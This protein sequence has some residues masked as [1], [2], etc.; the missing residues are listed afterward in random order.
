M[1]EYKFDVGK[2]SSVNGF[3]R[4]IGILHNEGFRGGQ[5]A[6]NKFEDNCF[7]LKTDSDLIYGVVNAW[8]KWLD[9]PESM[10]SDKEL[11]SLYKFSP[12]EW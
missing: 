4:L 8:N 5:F 9:N 11:L 7:V 10:M 1:E 2:S 6:I 12:L 3:R